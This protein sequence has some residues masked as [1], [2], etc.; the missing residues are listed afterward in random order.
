MSPAVDAFELKSHAL[1]VE[2]Y[3]LLR[4]ADPVR[5]RDA[6]ARELRAV[7]E[8]MSEAAQDLLRQAEGGS[9]TLRL[10][11]GELAGVL[12][13]HLPAT[14]VST[15]QARAAWRA[16]RARAVPAYESLAMALREQ[17]LP[18]PSLRPT[19]HARSLLHVSN[20]ALAIVL[21][22][23][24]PVLLRNV[25]VTGV[26]ALFWTLELTRR[27]WPRWNAFLM[28]LLGR[29]AHEHERVTVNSS[30][31]F[32]TALTGLA[33]LTDSRV[34]AP[35]LAVLAVA[36]P[37]A[38]LVGR[39]WGKTP[40]RAGR[41]LEGSLAFLFSGALAAVPV[42][43]LADP[44]LAWSTVV[45]VSLLAALFGALAELWWTWPDD[46][47]SIPIGASAGSALALALLV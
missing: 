26:A 22:L 2:L 40:I 9:E 12:E 3:T 15:D 14:E 47:L 30:T 6:R 23:V 16:F 27:R 38:A 32:A 31:W 10:R 33:W 39:R 43:R 37:V 35:A 44:G 46:N 21:D 29:F 36:D 13:T 1:A 19:N 34:H 7:V 28:S 42:L 8:R 20:G 24:L 4:S 41:S 25:L 5:W 11:L 17:A 45:G 18:V